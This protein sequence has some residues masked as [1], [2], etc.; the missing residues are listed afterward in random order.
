MD[1]VSSVLCALIPLRVLGTKYVFDL[2]LWRVF[3]E[4]RYCHD[5]STHLLR[6]PCLRFQKT[7]RE[8]AW[9][10]RPPKWPFNFH[11]GLT[12]LGMCYVVVSIASSVSYLQVASVNLANDLKWASFSIDGIHTCFANWLNQQL[13]LGVTSGNLRL[14][15]PFLLQPGSFNGPRGVISGPLLYGARLQYTE[16]TSLDGAIS[17]LRHMGACNVP[18]LATSYCFLD[19][20]RS[21][22]L[23]S[24]LARQERCATYADNAAVYVEAVLRNVVWV[25]WLACWG[26]AFAVAFGNDLQSSNEGRRWLTNTIDAQTSILDEVAYWRRWNVT[27]FTPAW[28]NFKLI[29]LQNA[30]T[31]QNAYG[32]QY[33]FTLQAQNGTYRL[34]QQTTFKMNWPL[35]KD[36]SAVTTNSSGIHGCSL[37]ATSANYAFANTTRQMLL[38]L[39]GELV[40]PLSAGSQLVASTLGPY[41]TIDTIYVPV[42]PRISDAYRLL[43]TGLRIALNANHSA[44]ADFFA[45][46]IV[47]ALYPV[48]SPWLKAPIAA[49]GGS[50]LCPALPSTS[51]DTAITSG[52]KNVVAFSA[53]CSMTTGLDAKIA[54]TTD[55]LVVAALLANT[56]GNA[57]AYATICAHDPTNLAACP[58]YLHQ[59]SDFVTWHLPT[60]IRD[61]D[62]LGDGFRHDLDSLNV[63]FMQYARYPGAPA[64]QLATQPLFQP[65]RSFD[66]FAWCFVYDWVIGHREVVAF[67]GDIGNL[68]LLTDYEA[69]LTHDAPIELAQYSRLVSTYVT[70]VMISIACLV[71]LY[72]YV[73][74]GYVEA[75]NLLELNRV[76]GMVWVGRPLLAIRSLSAVALLA[77]GTIEL[78]YS[79]H[80]SRFVEAPN[81]WYKTWLVATEVTW[82]VAIVNDVAMVFTRA[83]T[84]YYATPNSFLVWFITASL[85][86]FSPVGHT[87]TIDRTCSLA[88]L[89]L[90]VVCNSGNI[91]IGHVDRL[92][93]IVSIVVGCN[94][95]CFLT[96]WKWLRNASP[97]SSSDSRMLCAGAKYLFFDA[98]WTVGNIY[99]LDRASAV[100][101]GILT[102]RHKN[103]FFALDIKR[104]CIYAVELPTTWRVPEDHPLYAASRHAFP[105][106]D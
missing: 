22:A 91:V 46:S 85:S 64:L 88:D 11:R 105:L 43:L 92:V 52:M 62:E 8:L 2:R 106:T 27:H 97:S 24:S 21:W 84:T 71:Q 29:G 69:P 38:V 30:Y 20:N 51:G 26:D 99:Y 72:I 19:A 80:V 81:A 36:L 82:L 14:D 5:G 23:A 44:Q 100:L 78:S 48:P 58:G 25:D 4:E 98:H 93:L 34:R 59:I 12:L 87:V 90:Q 103:R 83:H 50:P 49:F 56:I 40:A 61:A 10:R 39:A 70:I 66:F 13:V 53:S 94:V 74:R 7:S 76:G 73:A 77:T 33:A 9:T 31:I 1:E 104:W 79:G 54:P 41:G 35:T 18:F 57:S 45:I 67:V 3:E 42:P 17:A 15:S 47:D 16:A 63:S 101:N 55:H 28:Q 32:H 65:S 89:D 75:L 68:T 86:Y 96:A 6:P 37:L 95:V 60:A 102:Y